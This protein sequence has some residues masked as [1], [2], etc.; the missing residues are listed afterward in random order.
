MRID[1]ILVDDV[2]LGVDTPH[3]LERARDMI[4]ARASGPKVA[5][6]FGSDPMPLS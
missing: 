6:T 4:A 3:D 1:A 2:P 5:S